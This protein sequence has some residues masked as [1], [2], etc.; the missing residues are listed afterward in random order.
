MSTVMFKRMNWISKPTAWQQTM[1][2]RQKRLESEQRIQEQIQP[3]V[4]GLA[5]AQSSYLTGFAT[6][7]LEIAN[8]R[9]QQ[10]AQAKIAKV[11]AEARASLSITA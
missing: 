11:Q 8:A 10:E 4:D 2:W 5:N 1:G 9:I 7:T 6:I 3:I